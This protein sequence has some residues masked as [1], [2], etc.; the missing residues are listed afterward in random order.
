MKNMK[1]V[2]IGILVFVAMTNLVNATTCGD[3]ITSNTIL[4]TDLTC[5]SGNG[6]N[7]GADN[8]YLDCNGHT[9]TGGSIFSHGVFINDKDSITVKNCVIRNFLGQGIVL[10]SSIGSTIKDNTIQ[11]NLNGIATAGVF[12]S[13]FTRNKLLTN[14]QRGILVGYSSVNTFWNNTFS[15]NGNSNAYEYFSN[16]NYWNLGTT[17]NT[18][19]DY[20]GSGVYYVDGEGDGIDYYPK[21][22]KLRQEFL[23][24]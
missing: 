5:L 6:I 2:L 4:T 24:K 17:G 22:T 13:E 21:S 10:M 18:W 7:I 16:G 11:N 15:G 23:K 14:S 1:N 12:N 19:S 3:T 8:I 9:I 20:S